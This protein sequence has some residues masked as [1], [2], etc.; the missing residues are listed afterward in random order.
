MPKIKEIKAPVFTRRKRVAAYA[1]VS[2][3][4]LAHSLSAQMDYYENFIE[5]NPEWS[6]V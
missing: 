3:D 2:V 4:I 1:R 5:S 6:F